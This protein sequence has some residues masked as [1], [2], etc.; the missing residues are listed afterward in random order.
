MMATSASFMIS[1][2]ILYKIYFNLNTRRSLRNLRNLASLSIFKSY[3]VLAKVLSAGTSKDSL[4][5]SSSLT[6]HE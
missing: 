5:R 3:G 4:S 2:S 1:S 6:S